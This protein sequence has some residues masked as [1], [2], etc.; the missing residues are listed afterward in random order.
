[1]PAP[2][3]ESEPA[4]VSATGIMG[5]GRGGR[6]RPAGPQAAACLRSSGTLPPFSASLVM[7][8]LCSQM[9]MEAE[10]LVSPE[11]MERRRDEVLALIRA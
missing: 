5:R 10:S 7:T 9:F 2:P 1:M 4:I 6:D 3:P 8:C 11:D